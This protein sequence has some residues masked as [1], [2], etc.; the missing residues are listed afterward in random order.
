MAARVIGLLLIVFGLFVLLV[1][2]VSFLDRDKVADFGRVEITRTHRERVGLSPILG[3]AAVVG[4]A[5]LLLASQRRH[6]TIG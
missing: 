2:S 6:G 1:G 3:G 5:L 4:G